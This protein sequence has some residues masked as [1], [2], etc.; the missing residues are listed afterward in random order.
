MGRGAGGGGRA[1]GGGDGTSASALSDSETSALTFYKEEGYSD[2]NSALRNGE[3]YDSE[4]IN[5]IDSA[6]ANSETTRD[7]V[8]YRGASPDLIDQMSEGEVFNDLGYTST[9]RNINTAEDFGIEF[10]RNTVMEIHVPKGSNALHLDRAIEAARDEKEYLLPR[11][12]NFRIRS[13]ETIRDGNGKIY[14]YY[15]VAD[16][17][18]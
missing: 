5:P 3:E 12:S 9:T 8:L 15:V 7:L 6:I 17:E 13:I 14:Q 18:K 2:I 16:Y 4:I 10:G 1:G 11:N